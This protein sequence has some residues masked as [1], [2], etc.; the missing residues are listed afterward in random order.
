MA[1]NKI[2]ISEIL[3]EVITKVGYLQA[4]M[5][6]VA[7]Q[8]I[9]VAKNTSYL[10][11]LYLATG[12]RSNVTYS[13]LADT[14][15]ARKTANLHLTSI[16]HTN[17]SYVTDGLNGMKFYYNGAGA[18]VESTTQIDLTDFVEFSFIPY[19]Q[20]AAS[21]GSLT[22]SLKID[23]VI[24]P[25]SQLTSN[26]VPA[27]L[28]EGARVTIDCSAMSVETFKFYVTKD[29]NVFSTYGIKYAYGTT[30][31]G[32]TLNVD[33]TASSVVTAKAI[34]MAADYD[35][36]QF[37]LAPITGISLA[38][39]DCFTWMIS[40]DNSKTIV[41]VVDGSGVLLLSDIKSGEALNKLD[42]PT[43]YLRFN[44]EKVG[45]I[46]PALESVSYLYLT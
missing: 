3:G 40:N 18:T 31:L 25:G 14:L 10:E 45:G 15:S 22:G 9:A 23:D 19:V 27:P 44:I 34:T 7:N 5:Q 26:G 20:G 37:T 41:D 1:G 16:S 43:F 29:S 42:T 6:A 33:N 21:G 2:Y 32:R 17:G 11:N 35:L 8:M 46:A 4:D 39:W 28:V 24:V 38:G 36:T 12:R 30:A 13:S